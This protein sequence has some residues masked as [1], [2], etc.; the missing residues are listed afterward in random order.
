[1]SSFGEESVVSVRVVGSEVERAQVVASL[2]AYDSLVQRRLAG[3]SSGA[4]VVAADAWERVG[5]HTTFVL[6]ATKYRGTV[7]VM[8]ACTAGAATPPERCD[9]VVLVCEAAKQLKTWGDKWV[10]CATG[11]DAAVRFVTT[12][13]G[14]VELDSS[15]TLHFEEVCRRVS[16]MGGV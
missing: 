1:M 2:R 10:A 8:V 14:R 16:A 11:C 9:G 13:R 3:E 6:P 15:T 7:R 4:C 12:A 5:S